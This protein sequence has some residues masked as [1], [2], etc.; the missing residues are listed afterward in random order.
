LIKKGP[1]P[2]TFVEEYVEVN[3]ELVPK[4]HKHDKK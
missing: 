1:A 4:K 3:G 2:E